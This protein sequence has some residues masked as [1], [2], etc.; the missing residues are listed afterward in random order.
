MYLT[1]FKNKINGY[2]IKN[3]LKNIPIYRI[4]DYFTN[5]AR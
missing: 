2:L 1:G 5:Y 3:S 4:F